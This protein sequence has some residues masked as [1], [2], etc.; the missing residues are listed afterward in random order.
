MITLLF[1]GHYVTVTLANCKLDLLVLSKYKQNIF[2][3][4]FDNCRL[5]YAF[6]LVYIL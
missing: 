2:D 1:A 5:Y 4:P 6:P 3:N